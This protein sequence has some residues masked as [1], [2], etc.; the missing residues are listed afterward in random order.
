[1][2]RVSFLSFSC[3]AALC[4]LF[5]ST[6]SAATPTLTVGTCLGAS[7]YTTIQAAVTAAA[8]GATV[9]VCPGAYPEQVTI[10]KS[11]NLTGLLTGTSR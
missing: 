2:S 11:L 4:S 1:M 10:T 9:Q 8:S 3:G 5:A 7:P 6:V